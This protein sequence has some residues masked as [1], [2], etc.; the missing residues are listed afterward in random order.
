MQLQITFRPIDGRASAKTANVPF[1]AI[2]QAL[3]SVIPEYL[4]LDNKIR[5][6][7]AVRISRGHQISTPKIASRQ[8]LHNTSMST[9]PSP[10]PTPPT[11]LLNIPEA[12]IAPRPALQASTSLH[13]F[14]SL[15]N[16]PLKLH[17][18]LKEGCGGQLWPAGM[19]LAK[20]L[21]QRP[22]LWRGKVMFVC[23]LSPT[24][25]SH[26]SNSL[27]RSLLTSIST[28]LSSV[29]AAALSV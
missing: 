6:R 10:S 2:L 3:T 14:T 17:E 8:Q 13:T 19:V 24:L 27:H 12:L 25:P 28:E 29:P 4:Y 7:G 15:L 18:D 23:H 16:P 26:S 11:P 1:E 21:L 5:T 20:Y 22:E 9:P